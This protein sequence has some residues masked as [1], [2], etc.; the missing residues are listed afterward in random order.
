M[1]SKSAMGFLFFGLAACGAPSASSDAADLSEEGAG[2]ALLTGEIG[3][4]EFSIS[5]DFSEA[6]EYYASSGKDKRIT[7]TL[8]KQGTFL[9]EMNCSPGVDGETTF[10]QCARMVDD[11]WL[12]RLHVPRDSTTG[13]VYASGDPQ[14]GD[15]EDV[16][17]DIREVLEAMS[18]PIRF[19]Y[20]NTVEE[21]VTVVVKARADQPLFERFGRIGSAIKCLTASLEDVEVPY[22]H[23]GDRQA[24]SALR[25]W[26]FLGRDAGKLVGN[27]YSPG[28]GRDWFTLPVGQDESSYGSLLKPLR[29]SLAATLKDMGG[30]FPKV[31][32]EVAARTQCSSL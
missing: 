2:L 21:V 10:Y 19:K 1:R 23:A 5:G 32:P 30:V 16:P 18:T 17:S 24:L 3:S 29:K 15:S 25:V 27:V 31:A 20:T 13:H 26:L 6:D 8:S 14:P 7:L 9:S 22:P 4:A 12:F 28:W 11:P